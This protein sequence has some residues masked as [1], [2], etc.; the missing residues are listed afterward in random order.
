MS[1]TGKATTLFDASRHSTFTVRAPSQVSVADTPARACAEVKS[2]PGVMNALSDTPLITGAVTSLM[3]SVPLLI[4]WL[5]LLSTTRTSTVL[6]PRFAQVKVP[7]MIRLAFQSMVPQESVDP[8]A[9][10][11]R[12]ATD[13]V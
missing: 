8:A 2:G 7:G 9:M 5:P 4:V 1:G 11:W 3:V 13:T 12:S 6:A 10:A